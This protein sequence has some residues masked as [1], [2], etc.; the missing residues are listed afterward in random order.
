MNAEFMTPYLNN[1]ISLD[2]QAGQIVRMDL[3]AI[4]LP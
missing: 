3:T 2:L 1:G 4:A